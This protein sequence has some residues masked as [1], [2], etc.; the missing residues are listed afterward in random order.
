[1]FL[2]IENYIKLRK[3]ES[4][5]LLRSFHAFEIDSRLCVVKCINEYLL[6]SNNCC[7]GRKTQLLLSFISPHKEI[8]CSTVS[9]WIKN[10]LW[11]SGISNFENFS[12]HFQPALRQLQSRHCVKSVRIRSFFWSVFCRIRTEYG[13]I[14]RISLDQSEC[15]KIRTRRNSVFAYI[16]HSEIFVPDIF[17][18]VS[19]SSKWIYMAKVL[20][21]IFFLKKKCFRQRF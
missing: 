18:R 16:S 6:R 7:T 21:Q 3:K 8:T 2:N 20:P 11:L 5:P 13:E 15:G 19:W 1:M 17:C 14:L 12:G 9:K 10:T 4:P